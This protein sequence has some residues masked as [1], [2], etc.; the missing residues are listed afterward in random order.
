MGGT[1]IDPEV[2]QERL[3]RAW[4]LDDQALGQFFLIVE[5]AGES[6]HHPIDRV[7]HLNNDEFMLHATGMACTFSETLYGIVVY[8]DECQFVCSGTF[9]HPRHVVN[10]D[11][12][13]PSQRFTRPET[14][15]TQVE[16]DPTWQPSS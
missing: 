8:D 10:G 14:A 16:I 15:T 1:L 5:G 7:E 3:A 9:E 13:N 12:F 2:D 4:T 11:T 6:Y